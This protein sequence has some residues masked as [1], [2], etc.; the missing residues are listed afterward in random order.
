MHCASVRYEMNVSLMGVLLCPPC[1]PPPP[2]CNSP[3]ERRNQSEIHYTLHV[4]PVPSSTILTSTA[5]PLDRRITTGPGKLIPALFWTN[6]PLCRF[7]SRCA[8][9][10]SESSLLP[11]I[12]AFFALLLKRMHVGKPWMNAG[13]DADARGLAVR[14]EPGVVGCAVQHSPGQ[15]LIIRTCRIASISSQFSHR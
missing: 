9:S 11:C 5:S 1:L 2:V 13:R 10:I 7:C 6:F 14:V 4:S 12:Y 8:P 15:V 3:I